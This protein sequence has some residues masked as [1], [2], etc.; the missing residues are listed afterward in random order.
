[1]ADLLNSLKRRRLLWPLGVSIAAGPPCFILAHAFKVPSPDLAGCGLWFLI[2][3]LAVAPRLQAAPLA[4]RQQS[5]GDSKEESKDDP[6][7]WIEADTKARQTLVQI[8]GGL[9][10]LLGAYSA[11]KQFENQRQLVEVQKS[12]AEEQRHQFQLQFEN[13]Q[14]L[15]EEQRKDAQLQRE[16]E[17]ARDQEE[18]R[19]FKLQVD[20]DLAGA[21]DRR[22]EFKLQYEASQS[23]QVGQR[24]TRAVDQLGSERAE[25]RIASVRALE[26]LARESPDLAWTVQEVLAAWIRS[27]IPRR[28]PTTNPEFEAVFGGRRP[29][30]PPT[31]VQRALTLLA[32]KAWRPPVP[33]P[34]RGDGED[35]WK[36]RERLLQYRITFRINLSGTDLRGVFL[37]YAKLD[38]ADLS[39]SDLVGASLRNASL[40]DV[41][42]YDC[43]ARGADFSMSVLDGADIS[44]TNFT[45]GTVYGATFR[46][47][48]LWGTILR[49]VGRTVPEA[50]EGASIDSSTVIPT[51][52]RDH[53]EGKPRAAPVPRPGMNV[54]PRP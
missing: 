3:L 53:L 16:A 20:K 50:F 43:D 30:K 26:T 28:E 44:R 51:H 11:W 15:A 35:D 12:Q 47:A 17:R 52:I 37:D 38:A 54:K 34:T 39:S 8:V 46:G 19:R 41:A 13:Q 40:R 49:G 25:T 18:R 32:S 33:E 29:F 4:V 42:L 5:K 1:M 6:K 23:E 36:Y 48:T 21:E 2:A 24:F 31:E 45:D 14:R 10:L 22:R 7:D 27:R 9:V